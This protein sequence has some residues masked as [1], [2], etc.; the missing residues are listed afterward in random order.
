MNEQTDEQRN[1]VPPYCARSHHVYS[2]SGFTATKLVSREQTCLH[3]F[4]AVTCTVHPEGH[5]N[6]ELILSGPNTP[7]TKDKAKDATFEQ[8]GRGK[9]V[10]RVAQPLLLIQANMLAQQGPMALGQVFHFQRRVL[11]VTTYIFSNLPS[12][13]P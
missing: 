3:L 4:P 13:Q 9:V 12:C 2:K 1:E 10:A 7:L 11:K 5:G 6:S 8:P